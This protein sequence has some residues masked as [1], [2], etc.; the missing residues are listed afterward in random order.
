MS[1][2]VNKLVNLFFPARCVFCRSPLESGRELMVCPDCLT[3]RGAEREAMTLPHGTGRCRYALRYRD[4]VRG[5]DPA[6]QVFGQA[7][8]CADFCAFYGAACRR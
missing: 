5:G 2:A 7:P 6:L 8:V 3:R 4:E 1:Y